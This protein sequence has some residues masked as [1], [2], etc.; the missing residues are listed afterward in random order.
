MAIE[1]LQP[2]VS[3]GRPSH[4]YISTYSMAI[5]SC[6]IVECLHWHVVK[7]LEIQYVLRRN[8]GIEFSRE[9]LG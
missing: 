5:S 3:I 9:V 8:L 7:T 1:T 2:R 6:T 4:Y